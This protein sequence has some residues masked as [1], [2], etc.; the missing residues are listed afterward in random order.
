MPPPMP[1]VMDPRRVVQVA[2][3]AVASIV[4]S[5]L[6]R[7]ENARP[8]STNGVQLAALREREWRGRERASRPRSLRRTILRARRQPNAFVIGRRL[9]VD[10]RPP[11]AVVGITACWTEKLLNRVFSWIGLRL[12]LCSRKL[13]YMAGDPCI[14]IRVVPPLTE[15][16]P[17]LL[18]QRLRLGR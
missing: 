4:T 1:S 3:V 7:K 15:I 9:S 13:R 10:A 2:I 17:R 11:D 12:L 8:T 18:W 14:I 16:C 5:N 6:L